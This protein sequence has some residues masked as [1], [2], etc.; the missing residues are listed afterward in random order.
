MVPKSPHL[1]LSVRLLALPLCRG[2][3]PG[4]IPTQRKPKGQ[5]H[6]RGSLET[7]IGG[8]KFQREALY[9]GEARIFEG[10]AKDSGIFCYMGKEKWELSLK[11]SN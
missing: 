4:L 10:K 11:M 5:T 6:L 2:T 8:W 1:V 3:L 9:V 7:R